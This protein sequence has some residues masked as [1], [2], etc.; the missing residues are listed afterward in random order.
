MILAY[1]DAATGTMIIQTL[2]AA[3]VAI[4][5]I[6][7]SQVARGIAL[8]RRRGEPSPDQEGPSQEN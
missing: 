8:I 2:I 3:A 4:P 5:F 1:L 7:R 6:L